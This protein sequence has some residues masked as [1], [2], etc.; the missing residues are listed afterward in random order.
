MQLCKSTAGQEPKS[1]PAFDR[2]RIF[3]TWNPPLHRTLKADANVWRHIR[4]ARIRARNPWLGLAFDAAQIATEAH[5]VIWLRLMKVSSG[6][7]D[8]RT[9]SD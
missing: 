1:L 4:M 7:R 3:L 2:H 9:K 8:V 5:Q 6:A